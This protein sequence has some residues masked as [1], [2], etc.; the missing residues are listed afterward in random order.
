[1]K[2]CD[3][4]SLLPVTV[5]R[6]TLYNYCF[7]TV[8]HY[9]KETQEMSGAQLPIE[10]VYCT[11]GSIGG[12]DSEQN[13]TFLE[14]LSQAQTINGEG[15]PVVRSSFRVVVWLIYANFDT[16][17][18]NVAVISCNYIGNCS[19]TDLCGFMSNLLGTQFQ[20]YCW[21]MFS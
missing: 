20:K 6:V 9:T 16:S 8:E 14:G 15:V 2:S 12:A 19:Q 11:R 5:S 3:V 10:L 17:L 1:M 13:S 7:L 4:I 21:D 18:R